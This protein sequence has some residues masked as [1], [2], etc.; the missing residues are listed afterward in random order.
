MTTSRVEI[1]IPAAEIVRV[2]ADIL[3]VELSDGRAISA[4]LAWFPRLLHATAAERSAWRLIGSGE[5]IH[6]EALDEDISVEG[7]LLGHPSRESQ[8]S[9][10]RWL[11]A[12]S[13][14]QP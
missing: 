11:G 10:R 8:E 4:P 3:E 6:W 5:G 2:T 7:L 13:S 1:D 12:R 9:F 14:P